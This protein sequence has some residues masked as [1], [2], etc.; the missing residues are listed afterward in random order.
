[1]IPT[2]T[3]VVAKRNGAIF[4]TDEIVARDRPVSK[5]GFEVLV[6]ELYGGQGT[7]V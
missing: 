4:G 7:L 2:P 5:K 3:H 6:D 1:M